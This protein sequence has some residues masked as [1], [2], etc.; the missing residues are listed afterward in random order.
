MEKMKAENVAR[1]LM[2]KGWTYVQ[3]KITTPPY[4]V[5]I[6]FESP[7]PVA[8][9]SDFED[10]QEQYNPES[11]FIEAKNGKLF[12]LMCWPSPRK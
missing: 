4:G 6:N 7:S 2:E 8:E 11:L 10:L 3:P 5:Q 12:F 1:N 9:Q